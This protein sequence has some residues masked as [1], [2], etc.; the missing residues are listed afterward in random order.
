MNAKRTFHD[1]MTDE[2]FVSL[3]ATAHKLQ[4]PYHFPTGEGQWR[5]Q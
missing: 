2:T 1:I 5:S 3:F 4:C